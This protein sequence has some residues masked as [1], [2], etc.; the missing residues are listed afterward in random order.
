MRLFRLNEN[1]SVVRRLSRNTGVKM[2]TVIGQTSTV[3]LRQG[4]VMAMGILLNILLARFLTK[5][6]YG[7]YNVILAV[8]G[9]AAVAT[10]PGLN[11]VVLQSASRGEERFYNRALRV[12][13]F[14]GVLAAI[15][16]LVA[17]FLVPQW[18]GRGIDH[19]ALVAA[20]IFLP[21]FSGLNAW[22]VFLTGKQ[23]F[24]R[25]GTFAAIQAV[26]VTLV[27]GVT[28][29][30]SNS[31]FVVIVAY[32]GT[33]SIT[34][35]LFAYITS[36]STTGS[37]RG[38]SGIVLGFHLTW[39]NFLPTIS[40]YF[41]RILLGFYLGPVKVAEYVIATTITAS[42]RSNGKT[43]LNIMSPRIAA[44]DIG[45]SSQVIKKNRLW[46]LLVGVMMAA[47]VWA[48]VPVVV[49]LFFGEEYR[50]VVTIAQW[51]GLTLIFMPINTILANLI[52]FD[53]QVAQNTLV[54]TLPVLARMVSYPF[55]LVR[56]ELMGLVVAHIG[57]WVIMY[58]LAEFFVKRRL[59]SR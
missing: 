39:T 41:D 35:A 14:A 20:I 37:D 58:L 55:L 43:I 45:D 24:R 26:L 7:Q 50:S 34:N 53:E 46:I 56:Y 19:N 30:F 8:L 18:F 32:V 40:D 12:S 22:D 10:L 6:V 49:P 23:D 42:V 25:S 52:V 1:N 17:L 57:G 54:L 51:F 48:V 29:L 36:R 11:T 9:I 4:I 28:V 33:I 47:F 13:F 3:V 59:R 16:L 2:S 44:R 21:F 31:L 5:E 38:N 27:A 15:G